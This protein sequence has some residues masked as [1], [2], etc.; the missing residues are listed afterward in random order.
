MRQFAHAI[1]ASLPGKSVVAEVPVP[2]FPKRK[3]PHKPSKSEPKY[4]AVMRDL[5]AEPNTTLARIC[6]RHEVISAS[7]CVWRRRRRLAEA[8]AKSE[9]KKTEAVA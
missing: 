2:S 4:L 1:L 5:D 9:D 8:Q 7:F 3:R 6:V